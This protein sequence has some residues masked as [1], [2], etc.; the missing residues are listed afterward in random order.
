M[1]QMLLRQ[2]AILETLDIFTVTVVLRDDRRQFVY[3]MFL[4][5]TARAL[6]VIQYFEV[7][8]QSSDNCYCQFIIG[9]GTTN[10][11]IIPSNVRKSHHLKQR[12]GNNIPKLQNVRLS[13]NFETDVDSE[14]C[15]SN[16]HQYDYQNYQ[17]R[18]SI[19]L[20]TQPLMGLPNLFTTLALAKEIY[21][22]FLNKW[23]Y[24]FTISSVYLLC[25][26]FTTA[27]VLNNNT[28]FYII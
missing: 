22:N 6:F 23:H 7:F 11:K 20:W 1:N 27:T 14:T 15:L 3:K 8:A 19:L 9:T 5:V 16:R 18:K 25:T 21:V 2:P 13:C 28:L 24:I 26:L 17:K 10:T 12:L 4:I